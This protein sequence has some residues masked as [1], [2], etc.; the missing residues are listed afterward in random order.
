M[1]FAPLAEWYL[2]SKTGKLKIGL[3]SEASSRPAGGTGVDD[4]S[5]G[6]AAV[7]SRRC[8]SRQAPSSPQRRARRAGAGALPRAGRRDD[9]PAGRGAVESRSMST[10]A[11]GQVSVL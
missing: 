10:S 6:V 5:V 2:L 3:F 8:S 1:N 7:G 4:R 9:H 11:A